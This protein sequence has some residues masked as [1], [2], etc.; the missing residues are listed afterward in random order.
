MNSKE[1]LVGIVVLNFNGKECL[2]RC[3]RSLRELQYQN[4]F[5]VVVDNHSRDDSFSLAQQEFPRYTYIQNTENKGFAG[6]MNIGMREVFRAGAQWAWLFNNDATA[7][8][9]T[10][11][12]LIAVTHSVPQA[13]LLSPAIYSKEQG[14]LWFGKGRINTLRM[15]AEHVA[16]S[17]QERVSDFYPSEFLTGCALLV[18]RSLFEKEG[19]FDESFFLYYEDVDF[20]VRAQKK[21]YATLVVPG[22]RVFHTEQSQENDQKIYYLVLS[23]LIFFKK[24]AHSW[25]SLYFLVYATIRRLKNTLDLLF[26]R[27]NAERVHQAYHDFYHGS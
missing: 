27:K 22:A 11:S 4:F 10:L 5:V 8:P 24:Q 9:L 20:S 17:E 13:G 23:G 26:R 21:G 18:G 1:P 19:G 6:G 12:T 3:L 2:L 7:E 16:P 25:K 14:A 15:R